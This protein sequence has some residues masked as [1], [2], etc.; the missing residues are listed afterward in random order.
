MNYRP[1]LGTT[2]AILFPMISWSAQAF[3]CPI[4]MASAQASI[5]KASTQIRAMKGKLPLVA[6]AHFREARMSLLEARHHHSQNNNY[7]HSRAIVRANE[8]RGHALAAY[9]MSR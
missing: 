6:R 1:I 3:E 4:H 7:H 5:D 2:V 8:A 9:L